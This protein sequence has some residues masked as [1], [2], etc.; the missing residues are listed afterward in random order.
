MDAFNPLVSVLIP[1]YNVEVYVEKA[2]QSIISQTYAKLEIWVI[3]DTSTDNTLEKIKLFKDDRIRLVTFNGNTQ[4]VGAVNEVLQKVNGDLIAFQDADDWSEKDRIKLQVQCFHED[5]NLGICFTNYSYEKGKEKSGYKIPL[6]D[7]ALKSE[8]L[9]FRQKKN[10]SLAPTICATMMIT[11]KVLDE[12]KG[13]NVYFKGRVAEDIHWVYRILKHHSGRTVNKPLYHIQ[14]SDNSLTH[15]QSSGKNAKY[16]Y[17][18]QLLSKI[19][20]KDVHEQVDLLSPENENI[21]KELELEAC[22]EALVEN[23]K[24]AIEI[25]HIFERSRSYQLGKL[26]LSPLRLLKK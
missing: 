10:I 21:L 24:K 12:T 23:I 25:Q 7:E 14:Q 6:T 22:E 26:L 9:C 11:K 1:C 3:D 17:S 16:A 15:Q 19:I 4:K 2:I 8:F 5:P 20:Y 13:Y 18:W